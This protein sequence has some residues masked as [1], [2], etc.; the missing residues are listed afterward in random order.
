MNLKKIQKA[1]R[2][3]GNTMP[4]CYVHSFPHVPRSDFL[5]EHG[6]SAFVQFLLTITSLC[7]D[8]GFLMELKGAVIPLRL[9]WE[10]CL[11]VAIHYNGEEQVEW[12][13]VSNILFFNVNLV[14]CL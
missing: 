5:L 13:R 7:S 14:S 3:A 6:Y 8:T 10:I 2:D 12:A 11:L 4:K 9:Y 1:L